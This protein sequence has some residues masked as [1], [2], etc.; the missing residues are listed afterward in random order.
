MSMTNNPIDGGPES[1]REPLVLKANLLADETPAPPPA[2]PEPVPVKSSVPRARPRWRFVPRAQGGESVLREEWMLSYSDMVTLL[3]TMFVALSLV[4]SYDERPGPGGGTGGQPQAGEGPGQRSGGGSGGGMRGLIENLLQVRLASPYDESAAFT[5]VEV[6]DAKIDKSTENQELAII[7]SQDLARI[8]QRQE[9]LIGIRERLKVQQLDQF[10]TADVEGDGIRLNI[11][12]SILFTPGSADLQGRGPQVL[13]AL[14]PVVDNGTFAISVEGH[15]DDTPIST[16][17]FPSNWELS[18]QRAATVV[19]ALIGAGIAPAR[20]E[21]V[22]YGDTRPLAGNTD[23]D[24]RRENRR[25]SIFLR[26]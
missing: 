15:T 18:A 12:N 22:G 14:R 26:I 5:T 23:E 3:L 21:A 24:G 19:R 16:E 6:N 11:P 20:L 17:K 7:K 1:A 10:I 25:V 8:T 9:A 4:V 2:V 13:S